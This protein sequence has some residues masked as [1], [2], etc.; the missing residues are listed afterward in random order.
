MKKILFLIATIAVILSCGKEPKTLNSGVWRGVLQTSDKS[1]IP[2]NFELSMDSGDTIM[3]ILTGD[4]RYPV[5]D[6]QMVADSIKISMPLFSSSF[7]L[8]LNDDNTLSGAFK[9]GSYEM[10]FNATPN[11]TYR[12]FESPQTPTTSIAGRW[13]VTLGEQLL[14]GE[15]TENNAVVTGSFLTPTGDYRFF[16]GTL[17]SDN[18]IMLSCFD[19]GFVRLFVG[20]MA[21]NNT[22]NNIKMYSGFSSVSQGSAIRNENAVLPDAYSVTG[23]KKGYSTLNF[24]FPNLEGNQ[25]SLKDD[26]FKNK[27][28]IIQISGSWCPNCL[29]ET[30][31]LIEMYNKYQPNLEVLC[32]AFER[33][34]EFE[35]AKSEAMKLVELCG[36]P[37]DVLVTGAT[38]SDVKT[39]LI[40]LDNF[41][42][43][44]TTII[45][46]KKGVVRSIHSGFSGP[47]TG[48]H[49]KNFVKEFS[50]Q[51]EKLINE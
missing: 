51:I 41:K 9:K 46:D 50:E 28:T 45:I 39:T 18:K 44:P 27:V 20:D 36:V 5:K 19:G 33:S 8:K 48:V 43:F 24:S 3:Y 1:I 15:F 26:K 16:E 17:T 21:D 7:S 31:F 23:M 14:I 30:R 42:S 11:T 10:P 35:A 49:Y 37:Y 29:D 25:I 6:I 4:D 12:F 32:L 34:K 22:I 40:E 38:P 13:E 47:G 2:F